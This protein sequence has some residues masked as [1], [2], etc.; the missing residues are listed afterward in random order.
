MHLDEVPRSGSWDD[1]LGPF[2]NMESVRAQLGNVSEAAVLDA[3]GR[4]ELLALPADALFFPRFQFDA[5][6]TGLPDLPAVLSILRAGFDSPWT[7][8]LWLNTP[9]PAWDGMTPAQA[10]AVGH[11]ER[12]LELA[13]ADTLRR[14]S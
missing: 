7:H 14:S 1:A 10:L 9:V 2:L 6:N 8:A 3:V 12:V 5:R 4:D 11:H 13:R